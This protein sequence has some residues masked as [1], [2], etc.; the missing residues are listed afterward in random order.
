MQAFWCGINGCE[1]IAWKGS[2]EIGIYQGDES[3]PSSF[4]ISPK[5]IETVEDFDYCMN[6]GERWKATYERV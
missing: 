4:I 3:P 1:H 6:H 2:Y 5:R